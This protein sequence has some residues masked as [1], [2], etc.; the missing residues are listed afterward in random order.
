MQC[1]TCHTFHSLPD[2]GAKYMKNVKKLTIVSVYGPHTH[3]K[4]LLKGL[5]VGTC[6]MNTIIYSQV[7]FQLYQTH[8]LIIT[9]LKSFEMSM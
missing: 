7:K 1:K 2:N 6:R 4:G 9:W 5:I 8:I 3:V